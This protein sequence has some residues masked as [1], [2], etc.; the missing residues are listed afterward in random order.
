M[1]ILARN[2]AAGFLAL[3]MI[4]PLLSAQAKE[5][6]IDVKG[7]HAFVQFRIKHLGFSWLYGRFDTFDGTFSYDPNDDSKNTVEVVVDVASIDTSHAE[8]DKHLRADKYLNV[9]KFPQAKFVSTKY[10]STGEKSAKLT[11]NLTLLGVTKE[12]VVDVEY[13]GGGKDPWG[14]ERV[15]FEGTT[16]I[17][18]QD[19]GVETAWVQDVDLI[20]SVEGIAK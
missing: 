19:F 7:A 17:N 10:V 3:L 20:W 11:G 4:A 12:V 16:T 15:G 1:K 6:A 8:R 5:Y 14:G 13:I 2:I 9:A 18:A